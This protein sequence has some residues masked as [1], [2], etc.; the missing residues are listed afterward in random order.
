MSKSA[1]KKPK[2]IL[3]INAGSSSVKLSLYSATF[4]STPKHL[5]ASSITGLTSPPASFTYTHLSSSSESSSDINKQELKDV[6]NQ[7]SAF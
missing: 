3:S 2:F 1:D 4:S 6:T 7:E 5:V